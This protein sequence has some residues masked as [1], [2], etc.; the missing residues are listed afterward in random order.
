M[1]NN[2]FVETVGHPASRC[3]KLLNVALSN[4]PLCLFL[5]FKGKMPR[6]HLHSKRPSYSVPLQFTHAP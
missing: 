4:Q 2:G 5:E 6:L 3:F 1:E